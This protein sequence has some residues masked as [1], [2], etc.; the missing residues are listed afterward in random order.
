MI[1]PRNQALD[2]ALVFLDTL[3][4]IPRRRYA[5]TAHFYAQ[6]T[7]AGHEFTSRTLRRYHDLL[8]GRFPME[9][10]IRS[11]PYGYRDALMERIKVDVGTIV[12]AAYLSFTKA[13]DSRVAQFTRA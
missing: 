3:K 8:C 6:L 1:K 4:N 9:C 2:H 11:R 13:L 10:D 5:T 12:R 7:A